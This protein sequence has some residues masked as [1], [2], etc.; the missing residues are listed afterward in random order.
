MIIGD[1]HQDI[2]RAVGG[3]KR[4]AEAGERSDAKG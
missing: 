3:R 2:R 4:E 1:D